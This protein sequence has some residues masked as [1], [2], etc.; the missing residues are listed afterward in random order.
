MI[1]KS[2]RYALCAVGI[3]VGIAASPVAGQ[4]TMPI[5]VQGEVFVNT[6]V[7]RYFRVLQVAGVSG[8]YP[9]SIR[10]FSPS[11]VDRLRPGHDRHPWA[12]RYRLGADSSNHARIRVLRPEVRAIYNTAFPY[13]N[14]DGAIWA[15]R[16]L[17]TSARVG[18][19]A[20]IGP[21]SATLAP[22]VFRA[23]NAAFELAPN[24]RE[25]RMAF[26]D[27]LDPQGI[28]L[29]QRF[30]DRPYSRVHPGQSTVRLDLLGVAAGLSTANQHWGPARSHPLLLG[31]NAPGY[32]HGFLG[33]AAPVNLWI[34][35]AHGRVVWGK[36]DQSP[37]SPVEGDETRRF[38]SGLIGSIQPRGMPGLELGVARFFHT[39]WPE[40]GLE[41]RHFWKPL[42]AFLKVGLPETGEESDSRSDA[43]NQL[44][45]VFARWVL[46]AGGFE[47]YGE[48]AREDHN[49]DLRDFLLEPD[50]DSAYLIGFQK[51][52]AGSGSRWVAVR[53]ELVNSRITHLDQA[54]SQ[55]AFYRHSSMRQGHTHRGQLLGSS[56]VYGGGGSV[57]A[58]DYYHGGGRF[59]VAWERALRNAAA[60]VRERDTIHT[61]NLESLFFAGRFDLTAAIAADYNVNRNGG[62]DMLNLRSQ[63]GVSMAIP[64]NAGAVRCTAKPCSA[65]QRD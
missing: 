13:G 15:G 9:W 27:P 61:L 21:L 5:D 22:V 37:Y 44:A 36:L 11:E 20:R 10:S 57:L 1:S 52:W 34:A 29:P 42:E 28:D 6:E 12:R 53:G 51:V 32:L 17:T 30:G 54:R 7:E 64:A 25:G 24:G 46:P 63:V 47:L 41:R 18:V 4:D 31:S 59:T 23:E 60:G 33:T 2:W 45:S 56:V 62:G 3:S 58:A 19:A 14:N 16:G 55:T 26:A 8:Y 48:F 40:G 39:P 49:F 43:D 50:H 38:M 65:T 35:R